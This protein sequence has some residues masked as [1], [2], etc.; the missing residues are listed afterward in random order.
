[1]SQIREKLILVTGGVRS[2][3]SSFAESLA[4]RLGKKIIF[5]ATAQAL[6][7]EMKERIAQH[8]STRPRHWK[9]VE[10]PYRVQQII[11]E[12]GPR[13]DVVLVDCLT[14]L[15]SNLMQDYREENDN[16]K[17]A[18]R[19]LQTVDEIIRESL[20]C[21]S[22]VIVVSNEVGMGLVPANPQGRFFRDVLGK[23]NQRIAVQA[24]RVYLLV[25]G[26]P[27]QVKGKQP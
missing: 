21:Q 14:L 25:A 6:D 8:R 17:L 11:Q 10:E 12:N 7:K 24:D 18:D 13:M 26:I 4:G 16:Q 20:R 19:I 2:G 23:A 22:T 27:V 1:M 15:V 9:T 3:K 5:I